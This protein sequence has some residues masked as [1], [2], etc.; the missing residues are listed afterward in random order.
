VLEDQI[1][2][3]AV[4]LFAYAEWAYRRGIQ[5]AY[6]Y[7]VTANGSWRSTSGSKGRG[8]EKRACSDC[9]GRRGAPREIDCR[10]RRLAQSIGNP[11]LRGS[12]DRQVVSRCGRGDLDGVQAW[13]EWARGQ[14]DDM[15]PLRAG[16]R[17]RDKIGAK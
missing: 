16:R 1:E 15:D 2:E 11:S 10:C 4:S 7:R 6:E 9:K 8:R 17:L 5:K 13:A 12:A 3:I 14:A